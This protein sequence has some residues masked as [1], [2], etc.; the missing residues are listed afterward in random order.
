M[1]LQDRELFPLQL[2][3]REF[4]TSSETL[5]VSN[6]VTNYSERTLR[7][8]VV[9]FAVLPILMVYPFIQKYFVKGAML[10]A[11]KG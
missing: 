3:L 4:I 6:E 1:F 9:I 2:K 5:I 7:S 11:V 10:G 8:A